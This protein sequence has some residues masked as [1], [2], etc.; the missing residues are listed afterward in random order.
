VQSDSV[1]A[2]LLALVRSHHGDH[3]GGYRL[4]TVLCDYRAQ[5]SEMDAEQWDEA[6]LGWVRDEEPSLWGVALEALS[7]SGGNASASRY[8]HCSVNR[9]RMLNL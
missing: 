1:Q 4:A 3:D 9:T 7:S 2:D 5:L 8:Q 6:L